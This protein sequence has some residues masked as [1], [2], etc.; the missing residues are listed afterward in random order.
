[1]N[2]AVIRAIAVNGIVALIFVLMSISY[3]IE[4]KTVFAAWTRLGAA[5]WIIVMC[6][7]VSIHWE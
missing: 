2:D 5:A 1:M 3:A 6:V 4:K 7:F